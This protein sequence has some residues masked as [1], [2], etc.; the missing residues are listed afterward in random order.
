MEDFKDYEKKSVEELVTLLAGA[1]KKRIESFKTYMTKKG[2]VKTAINAIVKLSQNK[3]TKS[4]L[5]ERSLEPI[6]NTESNYLDLDKIKPNPQQVRKIY[7]RR[8]IE[9]KK[10]SIK[11]NK[12]I[13][14]IIV[15]KNKEGD[16]FL[17]EGQLRLASFKELREEEGS[18]YNKIKVDYIKD[19][20][21]DETDF[22][23]DALTANE[24]STKMH[25]FDLAVNYK[26]SYEEEKL[27]NPKLTYDEFAM[28]YGKTRTYVYDYIKIASIIDEQKELADKLLECEIDSRRLILAV[29]ALQIDV[30]KKVELVEKYN[31]GSIKITDIE[32]LAVKEDIQKQKVVKELTILDEVSSFNKVINKTKYS[33]LTEEKKVFVDKKLEEIKEIMEQIKSKI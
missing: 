9:A 19:E 27:K 33:K 4:I 13:T 26:L 15:Y 23:K 24:A 10:D 12:Q 29:A 18:K 3:H 22:R 5:S 16:I 2:E 11:A 1:D 6:D 21:Y 32:K 25:M 28:I 20:E 30:D 17:V 14:P 31:N 8:D 7:T